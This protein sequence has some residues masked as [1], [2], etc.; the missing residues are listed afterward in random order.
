MFGGEVNVEVE[1]GERQA[2]PINCNVNRQFS[3]GQN[4][5]DDYLKFVG[6]K[7]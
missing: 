1:L 7:I 6:D 3:P 5:N 4:M 2:Q